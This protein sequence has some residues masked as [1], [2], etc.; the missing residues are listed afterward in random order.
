M[1]FQPPSARPVRAGH[2]LRRRLSR[3]DP[4]A[5]SLSLL[6]AT[7]E[8]TGDGIL[9]VDLAG[10]VVGRNSTFERMWHIPAGTEDLDRVLL[11]HAVGQVADPQGYRAR[12]AE[13]YAD[14]EAVATDEVEMAD[15]RVFSRY[16]QP[17]RI[18]GRVVGRVW[19]FRDRTAERRLEQG[20]RRMAYTDELTG[21]P[22]RAL[23]MTR[24]RAMAEAA[25]ATGQP[26]GV[27]VL[28]LDHLKAVN[29]QL[30]HRSGDEALT[31]AATRLRAAARAEDVVARLG[32]DEFGVLL[33]DAGPATVEAVLQRMADAMSGALV[34]CG[35][36]VTTTV[37]GGSSVGTGTVSLETLLHEADLAMYRAKADGR[38]RVQAF[39]ERTS[40]SDPRTAAAE[41]HEVLADPDGM[42]VVTQPICQLSSGVLVG[43][44]ALSRFPGR[45]HREVGEWFALARAGGSAPAL[46]ARAITRARAEHDPATGTYLTLNVSPSVLGSPTVQEALA[47]DLS[48]LVVEVTEDSR[49]DLTELSRLLERLRARGARVAMDDTGA[50]YDGLRRL[51]R[52]RPEIV[53]LDRELVHAVH[54]H[55]EK[56][57]MVEA[58][59]SFCRQT[60]SVLCAEGIESVEELRALVELGV[61]LGQGWF[62]GRP[63][64]GSPPVSRAAAEAC[65]GIGD[66]TP[67][68]MDRLRAHLDRASTVF[69]VAQAAQRALAAL[70]A[71]DLTLSLLDGDALVQV[72]RPAWTT[73]QHRWVLADYPATA[74]CLTGG[75]V[76]A[77]R[78]DDPDGDPAELRQLREVGFRSVLAVPLLSDGRPHGLLEVYSRATRSWSDREVRAC[79][80]LADEVSDALERIERA[81]VLPV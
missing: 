76:L 27:A 9:V 15:G 78:A 24:G 26:M 14:P 61:H 3:A 43:H 39:D 53:K 28:D 48:G 50:G 72:D 18:E 1:V 69:D 77:V 30:G 79:R 45:G 49:L 68:D 66:V 21:L 63:A 16:T 57:A 36:S 51:V 52:L 74:A 70:Q 58:L 73:N 80:Y 32:G 22:N 64:V 60:G 4:L 56:R 34:L 46:E 19:S 37:S 40:R 23:F 12:V 31:V 25:E 54:E 29:D 10:R 6:A 41:V 2:G 11:A 20:L 44:E 55:P 7:L 33:P 17:Q 13:L 67:G 35:R 47:G 71:D 42:L 8:S 59:V 5:E 38:G 81:A 65:G 75:H 62:V